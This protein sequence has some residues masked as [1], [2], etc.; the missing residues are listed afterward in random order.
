MYADG[1]TLIFI[2][3]TGIR[4]LAGLLFSPGAERFRDYFNGTG[5]RLPHNGDHLVIL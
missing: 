2:I 3:R 1:A 4:H 5:G